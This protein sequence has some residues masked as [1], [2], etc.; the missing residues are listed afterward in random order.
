MVLLDIH[1]ESLVQTI[2]LWG[3]ELAFE[4]LTVELS[5]VLGAI[6]PDVLGLDLDDLYVPP[7]VP[8]E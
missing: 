2:V 7:T 5:D 8:P 6:D 1:L 3:S 4:V